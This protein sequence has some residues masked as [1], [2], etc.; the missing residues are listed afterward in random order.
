MP[1]RTDF[2]TVFFGTPEFAV[3][4]LVALCEAGFA[5][6]LVV[7]QPS[8]RRSRRGEAE[9]SPVAAAAISRGLPVLETENT[10]EEPALSRLKEIAPKLGIVVAFGQI[11]RKVVLNLPTHGCI[12][13]HPSMLPKYRG[14]APINWAMLDG[15]TDS[16]ITVMRLVRKL[17]AGPIL[18]Q[19][20]FHIPTT[21]TADETLSRAA[22]SGAT[23]V[24]QV[25]RAFSD[26]HPPVE[27][28]Q[29]DADATYAGML[30]REH[31]QIDWS[32]PSNR[33]WD[34]IRGVQPWPRAEAVLARADSSVE[35]ILVWRAE[36]LA[37][38]G[39]ASVPGTIVALETKAI[40]VACGQA[41]AIRLTELQTEGRRRM[42]AEALLRGWKVAVGER[43]LAPETL[44]RS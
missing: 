11:L 12:N 10:A 30:G 41:T 40:V 5:P 36:P 16:G 2:P 35:R 19:Q 7:T 39:G 13:L 15:V 25:V 28:P 1:Q 17:D 26:G 33:V 14:A 43:F 37:T 8:K 18:L 6:A 4:T 42:D 3:P 22:T 44:A 32:R 24:T 20:P 9:P 27:V 34:Q 21:E 23:L 29:N 38:G 31:G